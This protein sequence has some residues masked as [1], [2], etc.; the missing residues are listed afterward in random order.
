[1]TS[2]RDFMKLTGATLVT[3]SIASPLFGDSNKKHSNILLA[4][5]DDHSYPHAGAYGCKFVRTPAFDRI[6]REGILFNNAF[7]AAPQCSPN[8]ASILTGRNIWSNR[9]AGTHSSLFPR[10]LTVYTDLLEKS[11]YHVGFTRKGWEP[12]NFEI[13]GWEHNPAGKEYSRIKNKTPAK[14][15]DNADYAANFEAFLADRSPGQPFCFWYGSKE[16]HRGYQKDAG[17]DHGGRPE[18]VTVPEYLPDTDEVRKDFLDYA[19]EIEWFDKHLGRMIETLEAAGELDNTLIVVI[20]DNGMPFPHAKATLYEDGI[21]V[22]LAIRWGSATPGGQMAND[23]VS[24]IDLAPTFLDAAGVP[25]PGT[26]QGR[27][28]YKLL[29]SRQPEKYA[30]DRRTFIVAGRERHTC[31]RLDNV[32]YPSRCIRTEKYLYI[33]NMKPERDFMGVQYDDVDDGPTKSLVLKGETDESLRNFFELSFAKRP[34]FELYEITEDR[35]CLHNLAYDAKYKS[36]R[37]ELHSK[38]HIILKQQGDPRVLGYGDVF[39]SYPRFG[40]I[41]DLAGPDVKKG[42]YVKKF[43]QPNQ[44][45]TQECM[46]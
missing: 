35:A 33:H 2:R 36:V 14:K 43:I 38:L 34:E 16:P 25:M 29:K 23:L 15:M 17:V 44:S 7:V 6:A 12:G 10:D 18:D 26:M 21:H 19:F 8:R 24:M 42:K 3:A 32:G 41:R 4:I 11:G 27:S 40:E 22:P 45:V 28:L 20:G 30:S 31:A 1:M 46:P 37:T 13:T 9:E 39:E 5:S